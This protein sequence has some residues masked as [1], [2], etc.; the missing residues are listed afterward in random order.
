MLLQ[1]KG[2]N[3]AHTLLKGSPSEITGS[4][5]GEKAAGSSEKIRRARSI[6]SG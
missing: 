6:S 5:A 2:T 1:D 3:S 4:F